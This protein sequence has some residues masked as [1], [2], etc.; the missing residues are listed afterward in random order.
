MR[1]SERTGEVCGGGEPVGRGHGE[2]PVDRL[3][4][5]LRHALRA[6]CAR[7]AAARA[8]VWRSRPAACVPCTGARRSASRTG[9]SR[10]CR[11]PSGHPRSTR[12]PPARGSCRRACPPPCPCRSAA[13]RPAACNARAMPKS[14]TSAW[15]SAEQDVLGLDV[16]VHDALAVRVVQRVGHLAGDLQ[17]VVERQLTLAPQPVPEA[18]RPPRRASCTR[19]GRP[20]RRSRAP[21]GC[22]GA[23]GGR[24][25]GS[26][27]GSARGRAVAASS[28]CRTLSA[29]G[30]SCWRS[31]ARYTVAMP[32]RPSSRSSR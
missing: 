10:G 2:G 25:S 4:D 17:R 26:P 7:A 14:A 12:H 32:P 22:A 5:G 15:P 27:A 28:G 31:W 3:L 11:G 23:A 9:R 13:Q 8:P 20:L 1:S 24:W 18:T 6:A 19:A 21:A 30:R 16:A 29:T